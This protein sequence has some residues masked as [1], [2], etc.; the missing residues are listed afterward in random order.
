LIPSRPGER[1]K[2]NR[3][4]AVNLAK[5]LRAGELTAVWV[6]D[7]RHEAMR[8]LVRARDAAA[9]DYRSKRQ[10]VSALLLRLGLYYP[11]KKTW[12]PAHMNWLTALKLD[13]RE[14]RIAFEEMLLGVRQARERIKRLEQAI[15]EAVPDWT[16]AP[17][18]EALQAMRGIDIIGAALCGRPP[19]RRPCL[20]RE[21][22][23]TN[24]R[25]CGSQPADQSLITDVFRS[26]PLVCTIH[27]RQP[28]SPGPRGRLTA[29]SELVL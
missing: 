23:R 11:G 15:R 20:D 18:V 28:P 4:D 8:D 12:G 21:S 16:L 25:K 6:P 24:K 5:L 14:Q 10:N 27:L 29:C 26:R 1:V 2:T 17:V 3:R 13:H 22:P 19:D 7:E 9:K